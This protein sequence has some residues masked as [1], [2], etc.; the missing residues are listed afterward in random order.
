MNN[1]FSS[2][3]ARNQTLISICVNENTN[4]EKN[5]LEVVGRL[6]NQDAL[7]KETGMHVMTSNFRL[8]FSTGG[9]KVVKDT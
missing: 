5:K 1:T 9:Q 2:D 6:K 3:S 7:K 4:S 8:E